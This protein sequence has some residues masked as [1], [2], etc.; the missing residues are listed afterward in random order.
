MRRSHFA[1]VWGEVANAML[2]PTY[3]PEVPTEEPDRPMHETHQ[4][5]LPPG[6]QVRPPA[7]Y[8]STDTIKELDNYSGDSGTGL[9]ANVQIGVVAAHIHSDNP[10]RWREIV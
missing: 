9:P 6:C 4:Q 2:G 8:G 3:R 1:R 7:S 10:V 5:D